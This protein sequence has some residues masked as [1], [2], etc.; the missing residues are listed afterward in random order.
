MFYDR[1]VTEDGITVISEHMDGVRS[2]AMGIWIAAGSRD[3]RPEEAGVS[4]FLEHMMFKGTPSKTSI[5]ISEAFDRMGAEVN[6]GTDKEYTCYYSR[7][8][9]Q[10]A[11]DAFALLADMV[12]HSLMEESAVEVERKVVLEEISRRDDTPDDLVHE[13]FAT[14]LWGDHTIGQAV[15]GHRE[16][17]GSFMPKDFFAYTGGHYRTGDVVV[18]AA[19]NIDHADLVRLVRG[20]PH[21]SRRRARGPREE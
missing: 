11:G 20:E 3:E 17:V 21:A 5:E 12:S 7:V 9:D 14:A 13:L 4:H 2:V 15:L 1:T 6:A 18:A 8:L 19:G 10:H 16:T